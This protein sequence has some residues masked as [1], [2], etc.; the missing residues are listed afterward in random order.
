MDDQG[1]QRPGRPLGILARRRAGQRATTRKPPN[2]GRNCRRWTNP[3]RRIPDKENVAAVRDRR[4]MH[5]S[6]MGQTR[7]YHRA[8]TRR[9]S[10]SAI[11]RQSGSLRYCRARLRTIGVGSTLKALYSVA[12]GKTR[13]IGAPPRV[14]PTHEELNP[15]G[16]LQRIATSRCDGGFCAT[17]SG[18]NLAGTTDPGWRPD[19]SGLTLGYFLEP[20]Q[21]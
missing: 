18:L 2:G 17:L 12:R 21:G 4:D 6:W 16:V 1:H 9:A 13:A 15:D 7:S 19:G 20:F 11:T 14:G 5:E 3:G 10:K 8:S